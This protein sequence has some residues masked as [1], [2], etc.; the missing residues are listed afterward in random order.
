MFYNSP[1]A[2]LR[3][4]EADSTRFFNVY[5][6]DSEVEDESTAALQTNKLFGIVG[7]IVVGDEYTTLTVERKV[8]NDG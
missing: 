5:G 7:L 1:A 2:K 3:I 6:V 8:D 4:R